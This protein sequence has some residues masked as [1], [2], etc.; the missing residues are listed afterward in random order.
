MSISRILSDPFPFRA[1]K[2]QRSSPENLQV[3]D[4]DAKKP[5]KVSPVKLHNPSSDM[6]SVIRRL[7][8]VLGENRYDFPLADRQNKTESR[9]RIQTLSRSSSKDHLARTSSCQLKFKLAAPTNPKPRRLTKEDSYLKTFFITQKGGPSE[10]KVSSPEKSLKEI[11][12]AQNELVFTRSK[13][14]IKKGTSLGS[15]AKGKTG[16]PVSSF[17]LRNKTSHHS[18]QKS[19]HKLPPETS[20]KEGLNFAGAAAQVVERAE[21]PGLTS[22]PDRSTDCALL[23]TPQAK[24]P[25]IHFTGKFSKPPHLVASPDDEARAALARANGY[26]RDLEEG[27]NVFP[28][29][30]KEKRDQARLSILSAA[31][32]IHL[33]LIAGF[34]LEDVPSVHRSSTSSRSSPR[35]ASVCRAAESSSTRAK[36]A[37]GAGCERCF[38]RTSSSPSST[39]R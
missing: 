5:F 37:S 17:I 36:K 9:L 15:S 26:L 38:A 6:K 7:K 10:E 25:R 3:R 18:P 32:K 28:I 20:S 33:M 8:S 19:T 39:T 24:N 21:S 14:F 22:Q 27:A 2:P 34:K 35:R 31:S 4:P 1:H 13:I 30:R 11:V 23:W 29:T 16:T 12:P